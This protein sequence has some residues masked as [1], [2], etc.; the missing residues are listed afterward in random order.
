VTYAIINKA[1]SSHPSVRGFLEVSPCRVG[2]AT[3]AEIFSTLLF[4]GLV[5]FSQMMILI[6]L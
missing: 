5:N 2:A 1:F 4:G 6:T 3:E